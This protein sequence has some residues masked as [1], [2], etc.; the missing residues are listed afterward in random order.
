M[1]TQS[2]SYLCNM[3]EECAAVPLRHITSHSPSMQPCSSPLQLKEFLVSC[4][5]SSITDTNR[6]SGGRLKGLT[7]NMPSFIFEWCNGVG[8]AHAITQC[9][10]AVSSVILA[11]MRMSFYIALCGGALVTV[12]C[13]SKHSSLMLSVTRDRCGFA[14]VVVY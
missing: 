5:L 2:I 6:L 4:G 12:S 11:F 8:V 14:D 1:N 10:V 9:P 3:I 13:L 7:A